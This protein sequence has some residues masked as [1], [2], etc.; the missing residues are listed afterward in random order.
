M[1][2]W[3]EESGWGWTVIV[4]EVVRLANERL[5]AERDTFNRQVVLD[6]KAWHAWRLSVSHFQRALRVL[7]HELPERTRRR[8]APTPASTA[9]SPAKRRRNAQQ[10][11]GTSCDCFSDTAVAAIV[12]A[13]EAML[14]AHRAAARDLD[15]VAEAPSWS[16]TRS[17]IARTDEVRGDGACGWHALAAHDDQDP[18]EMRR[19]FHAALLAE[20]ERFLL[21]VDA[22]AAEPMLRSALCRSCPKH[23]PVGGNPDTWLDIGSMGPFLAEFL[24]GE[25]QGTPCR[26]AGRAKLLI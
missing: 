22:D 16:S 21:T 13:T 11:A 8:P 7:Q 6:D 25:L 20:P 17:L 4:E 14:T 24:S 19:S 15:G 26:A 1:C 5:A 9:A 12:V 23:P 10:P 3:A 18:L 2:A